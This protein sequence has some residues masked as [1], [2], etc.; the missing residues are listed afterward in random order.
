M[1]LTAIGWLQ[2]IHSPCYQW[3]RMRLRSW[4][5]GRHR[6][7]TCPPSWHSTQFHALGKNKNNETEKGKQTKCVCVCV[8]IALAY[9]PKPSNIA[10]S[11]KDMVQ[12]LFIQ[13]PVLDLIIVVKW[14]YRYVFFC[15]ATA[16]DGNKHH[17][18][19]TCHKNRVRQQSVRKHRRFSHR[20]KK[21]VKKSN[22]GRRVS[23]M[24]M[25]TYITCVTVVTVCWLSHVLNYGKSKDC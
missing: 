12:K 1:W 9:K 6:G 13:N 23:G 10:E 15:I 3:P 7:I 18:A 14:F 11:P 20:F 5:S 24:W 22:A 21:R 16:C 17:L 8:N 4:P 25:C 2:K 19:Q